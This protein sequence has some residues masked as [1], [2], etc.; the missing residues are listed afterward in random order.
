MSL[1][2]YELTP[3]DFTSEID[4][5]ELR[6]GPYELEIY[7]SGLHIA[8]WGEY[9]EDKMFIVKYRSVAEY[10]GKGIIPEGLVEEVVEN[11]LQFIE[12]GAGISEL[13][14][15]IAL[16]TKRPPIVIDPLDYDAI[17]FLL[18]RSLGKRVNARNKFLIRELLRR[19]DIYLNP[20]LVR[21]YNMTLEEACQRH[22]EL[23]E[24]ADVAVDV[25][26]ALLYSGNPQKAHQLESEW[27]LKKNPPG[28]HFHVDA[29]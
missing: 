14:P 9:P 2:K 27:L 13:I 23:Q 8:R 18:S 16:R 21:L 6:I 24:T 28:R 19:I 25:C 17:H 4:A 26:G 11:G 20:E 12:P 7:S 22:P 3:R 1:G 5:E 29:V 15:T 10:E